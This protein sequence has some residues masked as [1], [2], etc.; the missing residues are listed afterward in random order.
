MKH[1][2]KTWKALFCTWRQ[3]ILIMGMHHF[4]CYTVLS[5]HFPQFTTNS[6]PCDFVIG[7][8]KVYV[9]KNN[10]GAAGGFVWVGSENPLQLSPVL[11]L[12][13]L[14]VPAVWCPPVAHSTASSTFN[15]MPRSRH[16]G[17]MDDLNVDSSAGFVS[18]DNSWRLYSMIAALSPTIFLSFLSIIRSS[19]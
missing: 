4:S 15:P 11:V 13:L 12:H 8:V 10:N 18:A 5:I 16:V 7:T 9:V 1:I 2:K 14:M 6:T 17:Q 3:S 19:F